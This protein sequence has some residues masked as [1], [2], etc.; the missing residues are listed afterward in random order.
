MLLSCSINTKSFFHDKQSSIS[1]IISS[2]S[3]NLHKLQTYLSGTVTSTFKV[4]TADCGG[5]LRSSLF[6]GRSGFSGA[7]PTIFVLYLNDL[8]SEALS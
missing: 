8:P 2:K 5:R 4:G 7:F 6:P 3:R 1:Q